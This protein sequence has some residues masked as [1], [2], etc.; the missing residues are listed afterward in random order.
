M[1]TIEHVVVVM[2]ENRSF[3]NVLGWMQ[4][5]FP[6][7]YS[8]PNPLDPSGSPIALQNLASQTIGGSDPS[9]PGTMIPLLDPGE[10][11]GDMAQQFLGGTSVPDSDPWGGYQP[12][13]GTM[14]GFTNNYLPQIG[15]ANEDNNVGDV[16]N[17]LTADQ[18]PVTA[19]LA[20]NFAICDQWFASVP[21]Q[22]FVNR[23]FAFCAAPAI[24]Y[25][26]PN[27]SAVNDLDY[28][29]H[30]LTTLTPLATVLELPSICSQLDAVL[31]NEV[32]WKVYFHDY[33]IA[34][35]TVPYVAG[36]AQ[37]KANVNVSTFDTSDWGDALPTQLGA[38]PTTFVDDVTQANGGTLPPFSFIEPR[39]AV[40]LAPNALPPS[41]NHPGQDAYGLKALLN[42]TNPE[43]PPIDATGGELL[44][45]QVYN[46]LRSSNYWDTT[47]L[48]ITYDEPGGTYD[49]VPPQTATAPGSI[50]F[51]PGLSVP[52][53]AAPLSGDTAANGFTFGVTGGRVP[54]IIVSPLVEGGTVIAP[55]SGVFDHTSIIATVW[56]LMNLGTSLSLTA[57]DGNAPTLAGAL[58]S[59]NSTGTFSNTLVACPS[60]LFFTSTLHVDPSAQTVLASAGPGGTLKVT[61]SALSGPS[62]D[63]T[64]A[65][66]TTPG[67][68]DVTMISV[69]ISGCLF[70]KDGTYT[71]TVTIDAG[72]AGTTSIP[73]TL[74]VK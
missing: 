19:F 35:L 74:T 69:S 20:R 33:S 57:R 3:D 21:S 29:A 43:D 50:N 34:A 30:Y 63:P 14:Q 66:S 44:L 70:A 47:L 32:N 4:S 25:G 1:A 61:V 67:T 10:Q 73:V 65:Y 28:P 11:L 68:A 17:Y 39:Y 49:H 26:S 37:Y 6:G 54:A 40:G 41:S 7:S 42:N 58:N 62:S 27:Y 48:I 72:K 38:L 52:P 45:M 51:S 36:A 60:A 46:L 9:Y 53:A 2:L 12:A 15:S 5:G 55:S 8:N 59:T 56:E 23:L 31:T 24:V 16:M 13:D 71:G 22:T 64:L 18:L